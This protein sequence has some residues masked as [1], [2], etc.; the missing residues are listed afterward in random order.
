MN[1]KDLV[2]KIVEANPAVDAKQARQTLKAA[3]ELLTAELD[4]AA[5]GDKVLSP[6]GIFLIQSRKTKDGESKR[7]VVF[8]PR[9]PS[10]SAD[11]AA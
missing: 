11:K 3:A 6:L 10:A 7:R 4:A 2:A 8:R 1:M 5:E 9:V